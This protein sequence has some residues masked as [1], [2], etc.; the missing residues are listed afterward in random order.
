[1][2]GLEGDWNRAKV[3][4][5]IKIK[6]KENK[7]KA[8]KWNKGGLQDIE[9]HVPKA[10]TLIIPRDKDDSDEDQITKPKARAKGQGQLREI[11]GK[12]LNQFW[13]FDDDKAKE[14]GKQK[15]MYRKNVRFLNRVVN[16]Y[17]FFLSFEN[18]NISCA[19]NYL[20]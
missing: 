10:S 16:L 14:N 12:A 17:L 4:P 6:G 7:T 8:Q 15:F 20:F 13:S 18:R 2:A 5:N 19:I 11:K 3:P 9:A 1:V